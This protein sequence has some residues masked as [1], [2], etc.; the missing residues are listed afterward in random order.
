MRGD[1]QSFTFRLT[2]HENVKRD[3]LFFAGGSHEHR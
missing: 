1:E 2:H 3:A